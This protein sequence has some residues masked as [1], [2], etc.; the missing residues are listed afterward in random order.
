MY[1][2]FMQIFSRFYEHKGVMAGSKAKILPPS[3]IFDLKFFF[4]YCFE[5]GPIKNILGPH[6]GKGDWFK[7]IFP[8]F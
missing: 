3:Y 6:G 8:S 2:G 5:R 1:I 7:P 4:G